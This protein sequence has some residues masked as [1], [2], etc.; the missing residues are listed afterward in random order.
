MRPLPHCIFEFHGRTGFFCVSGNSFERCLSISFLLYFFI[1][2]LF[3]LSGLSVWKMDREER[4]IRFS[5]V[6]S[7]S[8]SLRGCFQFL[9][10]FAHGCPGSNSQVVSS[11]PFPL[12]LS[13]YHSWSA[14]WLPPGT[15]LSCLLPVIYQDC[16]RT[17]LGPV[18]QLRLA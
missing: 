18:S 15:A 2:F 12:S 17:F 10:C 5:Q 8:C 6:S 14:C 3:L 1:S 9:S 7:S 16:S 13:L 11:L 4:C